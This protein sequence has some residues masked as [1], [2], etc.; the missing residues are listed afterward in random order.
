[1]CG[2]EKWNTL[3]SISVKDKDGNCF[4]CKANDPKWLNGEY[5]T[6][7]T[8]KA[9]VVNENGEKILVSKEDKIKYNLH[10]ITYHKTLVFDENNNKVFIDIND[11][12]FL[13]GEYI[14][15]FKNK[16][17]V[18]DKNGKCFLIDKNDER[19]IRGEVKPVFYGHHHTKET[20]QK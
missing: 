9:V 15:I 1:M 8:G 18:K 10:G 17:P 20:K 14:S 5:F 6:S 7:T 11:P 4:R 13:S 2:G 3:N 16:L 19:Y 12:R